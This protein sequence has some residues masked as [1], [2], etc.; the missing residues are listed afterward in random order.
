MPRHLPAA[1]IAVTA[2]FGCLGPLAGSALA[3]GST[4]A[5][6]AKA[7]AHLYLD[8]AF[9][10]H[11]QAVDVPG[12]PLRVTGYVR[13]YV[14]GQTATVQA[15]LGRRRF[16]KHTLRI[17]PTK[18]PGIGRFVTTVTAPAKGI[19]H[20]EASHRRTPQLLGFTVRRGVNSLAPVTSSSLFS[21]LVQQRLA[22]LHFYI[23][24]TGRWGLQTELA[25]D[26]YHRLLGRGTSQVLDGPTLTALLDGKGAFTVRYPGDGTHVEGDLGNQLLALIKGSKVQAIYPISSGKPSTPTILGRYR[27]YL[28]TPG[29]LPDGMYYSD[30]F[31]RGYA[32]HGYDPAPDYPASHGCMRLPISDA[33]SVFDWLN[34]GDVVDV[35]Q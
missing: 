7:T 12:R 26:A 18:S 1:A 35:Y 27:V 21:A 29:Y 28:R 10:V 5:P 16:A 15:Y 8:N 30:F 24:Q 2:A 9:Q 13:P 34:L 19:V 11:H 22:K 4:T 6:A 31:I 23:P 14:P 20:L 25:I 32:I 17:R 3:A 33:I